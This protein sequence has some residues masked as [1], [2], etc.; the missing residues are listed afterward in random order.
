MDIAEKIT[1]RMKELNLNQAELAEKS[2]LTQQAISQYMR[3]KV[4]P[5]FDSIEALLEG[6]EVSA[7]WLFKDND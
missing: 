6:L 1:R 7:N 2:G 4:K 5:G 3:G